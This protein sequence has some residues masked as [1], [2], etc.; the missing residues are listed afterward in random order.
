M[1]KNTKAWLCLALLLCLLIGAVPV[2]AT[3]S[4]PSTEA[5]DPTTQT[6]QSPGYVIPEVSGN[7]SVT[8]GCGT[9]DAQV[10]LVTGQQLLETT[11]AAI[12][13]EVNTNTLIYNWNAD[14]KVYPGSLGKLMTVLVALEQGDLED[15]VTVSRTALNELPMGTVVCDLQAGE[16]MSL[17]D[18]LYCVMVASA[19]DAAVV[20][21]HHISGS[22]E[23]FVEL[24]NAKALELGC[25]GTNFANATGL[26]S[27]Q[28]Y[29]T[30]RD[31]GKIILAGFENEL[32]LEMFSSAVY[33]VPA[34]NMSAA[35]ELNTTNYLQ[36]KVTIKR[37]F[38]ERCTG[39]KTGATEDGGR[40]LVATAESG[41]T[42]LL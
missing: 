18:L 1:R 4:Q 35:R 20:V 27:E 28:E 40:S 26:H 8:A 2:G 23:D 11:E 41:N 25:T 10:P 12:L 3:S 24:L 34:T 31:L 17:K 14:K 21:A 16:E 33:T 36:S 6:P 19:N 38:D 32:F 13:Y 29:T 7:A 22:Q 15:T 42:C 30:A 39:G 9:M 5:S 37:Y